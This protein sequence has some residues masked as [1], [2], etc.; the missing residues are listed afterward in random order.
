M[1][2]GTAKSRLPL[3]E[4]PDFFNPVILGR[5]LGINVNKAYKLAKSPGF[6]AKRIGK[7]KIII[8]KTGLMKWMESGQ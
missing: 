2:I 4:A 8:S 5:I 1:C 6:P 7:K 3:D